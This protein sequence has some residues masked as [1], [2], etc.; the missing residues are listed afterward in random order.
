MFTSSA[1]DTAGVQLSE[2]ECELLRV[3]LEVLHESGYD[4]L[5]VDEV[6]AR[7]KASKA[8]LYRRWP[9][10]ADL[11]VAAFKHGTKQGKAFPDTGT[12]RGD[13]IAFGMMMVAQLDRYGSAVCGVLSEVRRSDK[14]R[15]AFEHKFLDERRALI[16]GVLQRAVDRGEIPQSA[17]SDE[18]WDILPG[19]LLFRTM[20][21]GRPPTEHTVQVLVDDVVLPALTRG[22]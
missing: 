21:P 6:A 11:V 17:I 18:V 13:L 12:L 5:T 10:K 22:R 1:P 15:D 4:G 14:L 8:T 3:T 2:R 7:A 19:Y 16:V 9:T 20:S